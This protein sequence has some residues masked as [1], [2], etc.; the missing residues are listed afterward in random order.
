MSA[1]ASQKRLVIVGAPR[2]WWAATLFAMR[3]TIPQLH[4]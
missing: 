1:P 4:V 2:A 3:S